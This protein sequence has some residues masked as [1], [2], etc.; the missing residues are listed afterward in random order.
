CI[1]IVADRHPSNIPRQ[2]DVYSRWETDNL[3]CRWKEWFTP[4]GEKFSTLRRN[5]GQTGLSVLHSAERRTERIVCSPLPPR[6]PSPWRGLEVDPPCAAAVGE[7]EERG[8]A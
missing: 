6:R 8:S 4:L 1:R 2:C 3:V 5:G 7:G